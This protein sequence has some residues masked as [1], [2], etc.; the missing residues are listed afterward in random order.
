MKK[1]YWK[2][3]IDFAEPLTE[4]PHAGITSSRHRQDTITIEKV[5]QENEKLKRQYA[6]LQSDYAILLEKYNKLVAD[7]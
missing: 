7:F 5:I 3:Y 1:E 6:D 2:E 4:L